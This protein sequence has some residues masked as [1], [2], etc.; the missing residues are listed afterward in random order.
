MKKESAIRLL[1][2]RNQENLET[3]DYLKNQLSVT[4]DLWDVLWLAHRLVK[5]IDYFFC[6][7]TNIDYLKP[8]PKKKPTKTKKVKHENKR[9]NK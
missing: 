7:N 6:T 3:I 9:P 4:H 8:V 1:E 2:I 5:N